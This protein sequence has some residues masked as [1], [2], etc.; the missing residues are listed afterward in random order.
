MPAIL[1]AK[2]Y[3]TWLD[4]RNADLER[5]VALL[6]PYPSDQLVAYPVS[7]LVNSP[8]NNSIECIQPLAA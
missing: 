4:V 3:A 5:L 1:Q 6:G 2:D 8:R 7:T